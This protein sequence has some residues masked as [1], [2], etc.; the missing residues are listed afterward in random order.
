MPLC[1]MC[2]QP[3]EHWLPH[4]GRDQRS[5]LSTVLD[6]IGSDLTLHSCPHCRSN[7]RE[8]HIWLYMSAVGLLTESFERPILHIAPEPNIERKLR[9][10]ARAEYLGGDLTPQ[11]P[12]HRRLNVEQLDQPAGRF[13]LII[14]NHV[15][16]H[17]ADP[18]RAIGELARCL[19]DDGWLIAQ[20]P[21]SPLLTDTM[22]FGVPPHSDAAELFFGQKDH[23]RLFGANIAEHFEAAGLKGGL[24]PHE[25]ILPGIDALTC[26]CNTRE[27]FFLFSKTR[28][29][30]GRG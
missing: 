19:S 24:Y 26:G 29:L 4:P 15:L 20:T 27:P 9:S 14:C 28:W 3:V 10:M 7:D 16:E 17:V 25:A 21:Y 1:A 8:R 12:R 18:H 13:H 23:V 22:E 30:T 2:E 5:S 11:N 6:V